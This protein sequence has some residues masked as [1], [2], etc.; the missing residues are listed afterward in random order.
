MAKHAYLII[1][2]NNFSV[3]E[4]LLE[5]LD[6]EKNDIYIHIDKKVKN[7]DFDYYK[8]ICKYS[9]VCF[10]SKRYCV[11]WGKRS[12]VMAEMELFKTAY[13]NAQ[14]SWYH[15]IS[16]VDL[17]IMN[18]Q[19]IYKFFWKKNKSY[20]YVD[21]RDRIS[22]TQRVSR[23]HF[24]IPL[25][26]GYIDKLQEIFKINRIKYLEIKK[27]SNWG[28]F[29]ND[30]VKILLEKEKL[31]KRMV[32]AS[33]CADE[34]YKQTILYNFARDTIYYGKN[35]E[36]NDL[37]YIDWSNG[38]KS[39]KTFTEED[40]DKIMSSGNIFARKFDENISIGII[41]KIYNKNKR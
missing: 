35:G 21:H 33:C 34:V 23:F 32:F 22:Y 15:L 12:Q 27:G 36:T 38:G 1:A 9:K 17:P 14:Y 3:L 2:H 25:I 13:K 7:F 39:P 37:R 24:D 18:C 30:S 41:D 29:T 26:E 6:Y 40:Y 10:V 28:S 4:K 5:M 31:I 19:D 8:D 16:G 20:I 11:K